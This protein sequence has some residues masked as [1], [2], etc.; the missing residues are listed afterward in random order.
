M[1]A[2][3][4]ACFLRRGRDL[5]SREARTPNG[6]RDHPVGASY[7]VAFR[8][9]PSRP[10][11][12]SHGR[13][14]RKGHLRLTQRQDLPTGAPRA[15]I[16]LLWTHELR[17]T[18]RTHRQS[19][20]TL[21]LP[22]PNR[23]RLTIGVLGFPAAIATATSQLILAILALV[24][25]TAHALGGDLP[26]AMAYEEPQA[27]PSASSSVHRSAPASHSTSPRPPSSDCSRSRSSSWQYA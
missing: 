24:G 16:R 25:T 15:S 11:A 2:G 23:S 4:P 13:R 3:V 18:A 22:G 6:F 7:P 21:R 12:P 9:F 5:N 1:D 20:Q 17:L 10:P 27:C 14:P 8:C 19:R 26:M